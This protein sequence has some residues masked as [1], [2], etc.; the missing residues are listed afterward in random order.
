MDQIRI[1]NLS[2]YAYHGVF[3]AE[4]ENGQNFLVSAVLYLDLRPAGKTDDLTQSVHYGEVCSL[5]TQ[6]MT[7]QSY[8]LIEA[9]AEKTVREILRKWPAIQKI[10]FELKK[11]DAPIPLPFESV[12][13]VLKRG[14][15]QA[16]IAFGSNMGDKEKHIA[17]GIEYLAGN[18]DIEV[19]NVSEIIKTEP[20]GGVSQDDFLNGVMEIT[21][22][23]D[24]MELLDV[25]HE[26]EQSESRV[27]EIHWGPRT[28]DLDILF[29]DHE[30][31]RQE[32]L[33]VPHPDMEN[34]DFVLEPLAQ[35]APDFIHPMNGLRVSEMLERLQNKE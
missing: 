21:T 20:Y 3:D 29:Y 23:L 32:T 22:L 35:I 13:V 10:R 33:T 31:I 27:R 15:H 18:Q 26:A 9:A 8:D 7:E 28:L 14:R 25:L 4:K 6:V 30:V 5:I 24:P 2:V 34:R 12:S 1:D 19:V 16:Y 17:R 11:P